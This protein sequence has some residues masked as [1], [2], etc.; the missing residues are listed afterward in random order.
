VVAG[1]TEVEEDD[2]EGLKQAIGFCC[3]AL[4]PY[5]A[6]LGLSVGSGIPS[7]DFA[8]I[9]LCLNCQGLR[10]T[11]YLTALDML[12]LSLLCF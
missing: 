4:I 11:F 9:C 7:S 8:K 6:A 10:R 3:V 1:F 2:K 5:M 12:L